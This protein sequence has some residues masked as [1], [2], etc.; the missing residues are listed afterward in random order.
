MHVFEF[1]EQGRNIYGIEY[2]KDSLSGQGII[3]GQQ[4]SCIAPEWMFRFKTAYEPKEKDLH[5]VKALAEK[6]GYSIPDSHDAT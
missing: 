4:V 3:G 1:D 6:F 5:D 2:P